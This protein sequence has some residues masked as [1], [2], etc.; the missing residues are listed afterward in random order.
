MLT[1]KPCPG[2]GELARRRVA[3][4]CYKCKQALV[5]WQN[6]QY[7]LARE[8][9][10]DYTI[11]DEAT[12][13]IWMICG[14]WLEKEYEPTETELRGASEGRIWNS[15]QHYKMF[16]EEVKEHEVVV[17]ARDWLMGFLK[18]RAF[19]SDPVI[20][21]KFELRETWCMLWFNHY[22]FDIGQSDAQILES[23]ARYV[24]RMEHLN[25]KE[26]KMANGFWRDKYCLM[27]AED[28]DRW[29]GEAE[30]D[31]PCRCKYCK[32]QGLIRINH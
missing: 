9:S 2:C 8:A 25:R 26:G 13:P 23:F 19:A 15:T 10:G 28:R 14:W 16:R 5:A 31:P 7:K 29:R 11:D 3:E 27:G 20:Q 18:Q 24:E 6:Q 30:T 22:T 21:I 32:E 17:Y 12:Y 4:L 1:S